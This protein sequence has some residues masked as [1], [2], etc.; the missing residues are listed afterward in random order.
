MVNI[1]NLSMFYVKDRQ[2]CK[3]M[4]ATWKMCFLK[5]MPKNIQL[6]KISPIKSTLVLDVIFHHYSSRWY[7]C[8]YAFSWKLTINLNLSSICV[9]EWHFISLIFL[10]LTHMFYFLYLSNCHILFYLQ[11]TRKEH[12]FYHWINFSTTIFL[13]LH[14]DLTKNI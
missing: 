7:H 10:L 11:S 14:L 12:F 9:I 13:T 5:T 4:M 1:I 3:W 8:I 2:I 6:E